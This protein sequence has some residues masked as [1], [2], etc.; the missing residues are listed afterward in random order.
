MVS[1]L[2]G[3]SEGVLSVAWSPTSGQLVS[4]SKD[5]TAVVWDV[6]SGLKVSELKGHTYWVRS[7]AWSQE[8]KQIAT[9]SDDKTVL[10]WDAASGGQVL[11]RKSTE[12][13]F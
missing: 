5:K 12:I 2:E 7:V 1:Q 4:G 8:G 11:S 10:V 13:V 6:K 3:H 9:G